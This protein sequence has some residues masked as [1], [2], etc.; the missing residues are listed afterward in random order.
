M[1][2]DGDM[3]SEYSY[4]VYITLLS[5]EVAGCDTLL[6]CSTTTF[7]VIGVPCIQIL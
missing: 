6:E 5:C 3:H 7:T 2:V 4:D 1:P